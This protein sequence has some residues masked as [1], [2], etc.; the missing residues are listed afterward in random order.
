MDFLFFSTLIGGIILTLGYL[1]QLFRFNRTRG[2]LE[3][4]SLLFWT[5]I[6][7]AVGITALN[8]ITTKAD[9]ILIIIQVANALLALLIIIYVVSNLRRVK[10][11]KTFLMSPVFYGVA[12]VLVAYVLQYALPLE[13][14]QGLATIFIVI[15]YVHQ[16]AHIIR[17]KSVYGLSEW[18]FFMIAIGLSIIATKMFVTEVSPHIIFT[19]LV[20]IVLLL[21][22]AFLTIY[23]KNKLERLMKYE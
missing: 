9:L 14:S 10:Q 13:I 16:L 1:P 23:K 2:N 6:F 11:I 18:L 5:L 20:N 12:V 7:T 17:A 22:C 15:A 8:L 19:E 21:A 4:V 3:G